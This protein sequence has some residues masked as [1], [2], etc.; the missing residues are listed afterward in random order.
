MTFTGSVD[1][2][3]D[4]QSITLILNA[5][6]AGRVHVIHAHARIRHGRYKLAINVPGRDT[7]FLTG[8]RRTGGDRWN[9]TIT[10]KGSSSVRPGRKTGHLT[11]EIERR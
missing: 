2:R 6:F 3:A 1:A 11:L 4:G 9:Y 8:R 10:Y 5:K 7:D